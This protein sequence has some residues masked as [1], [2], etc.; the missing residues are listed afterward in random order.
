MR[1]K[2]KEEEGKRIKIKKSDNESLE[3]ANH[4]IDH[5]ID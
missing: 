1:S 4:I 3:V 2:S 5:S